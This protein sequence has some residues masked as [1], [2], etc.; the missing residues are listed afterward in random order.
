MIASA[1]AVVRRLSQRASSAP[2]SPRLST[3]SPGV[4]STKIAH[5]RSR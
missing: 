1:I 4:E 3:S 5:R 2:G